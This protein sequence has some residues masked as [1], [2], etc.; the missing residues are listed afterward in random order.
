MSS[1][2]S[3]TAR[4]LVR[5]GRVVRGLVAGGRAGEY[6]GLAASELRPLVELLWL[7]ASDREPHPLFAAGFY[8]DHA[9]E[10]A[11]SGLGPLV[12]FLRFGA[13]D[14]LAPHP[15]FETS[16]YLDRYPDVAASGQN[17][18][19]HYLRCGAAELRSPHPLFDTGFYLD[20]YPEAA[21]CGLN[22]L[23][24]F[25][26]FGAAERRSPHPLFDTGYYL[27]RYPEA[28]ACGQN[29]LVHFLRFGA[30]ERRSPHPL[31][32][33]PFYLDRYPDVERSDEN[34]LLHY[35]RREA[36]ELAS[37]HP[38]FDAAY[39]VHR[40]PDV[41]ASGL[42]PLVHF[43]LFGPA[44]R[45]S[46][47]PLFDT[48]Y[49]LGRYPEVAASALNPLVHFL[50]RGAAERRSPHPLFD[51]GYY[52]DQS[53]AIGS[54]NPLLDY[55]AHGVPEGRD[56]HPL[57]HSRF[58]LDRNPDVARSGM[59]PLVHYVGCGSVERRQPHPL[60][61]PAFYA[62]RCSL[63]AG[64][65][66]LAHFLEH[67]RAARPHPLFDAASYLD[68]YPDVARS[69]ENPLAHYV[70]SGAAEGRKAA[71][72]RD[73]AA[74][75]GAPGGVSGER[76][77]S[78]KRVAVAAL[79][80]LDARVTELGAG[81]AL[82]LLRASG[83]DVS[84][85]CELGREAPADTL[86]ELS[87]LGIEVAAD[88]GVH[89]LLA[90]SSDVDVVLVDDD[91]APEVL[92]VAMALHPCSRFVLL[93]TG[94]DD[95]PPGLAAALPWIHAVISPG[96]PPAPKPHLAVEA[97]ACAHAT[98]LSAAAGP[99]GM[100]A[101]RT[102]QSEPPSATER[103]FVGLL[104]K[105]GVRQNADHSDHLETIARAAA[106]ETEADI[107]V[108]A[109]IDW[110]FRFQRPQ[111]L[112]VELARLGRRV[113]YVNPELLLEHEP[114]PYLF[115][116]SPADNVFS[117]RL[118]APGAVDIHRMLPDA[119]RAQVLRGALVA[120]ARSLAL[121]DPVVVVEAPFWHAVAGTLPRSLLVYDCM[122]LYAGFPGAHAPLVALEQELI[123]AADLVVFSSTPLAERV[124]NARR[125]AVVRNGCEFERF[126]TAAPRREG[127]RPVVGYVG[128]VDSWF[129][130]ALVERSVAA[131]PGWDF[132]LVGS[133]AGQ[134][135]GAFRPQPNLRLLGEVDYEQVPGLVAGFD[136][137]MVPFLDNE[138]TR[139][140]DPVKVYE[141]LAAGKP[142]VA[143]ALPELRRLEA[144]LVH[145]AGSD[146]EFG[147]AL[148]TAMR[149][150]H[151]AE[152]AA[153]RRRWAS[154]RSWG[155]RARELLEALQA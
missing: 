1:L 141:Y 71:A 7:G 36:G 153:R 129:D 120:V 113:A 104:R 124:T 147:A 75:G 5:L 111:Q 64:V 51:T 20:R 14:R 151:D 80:A 106:R 45:R 92:P 85:W 22:P 44:E 112:A 34:P 136:V 140:V 83:F 31:F 40:H 26:R 108:L 12:H 102:S 55:L 148:E 90:R 24:H 28:A 133:R 131:H 77:P 67:G 19:V 122:D 60:F 127:A 29:P 138:L 84:L 135:K 56:P 48:G 100:L 72:G 144:G 46:P 154:A 93:T 13:R 8:L 117:L 101:T 18:L 63:A 139:C 70:R 97:I 150:R 99:A 35:L 145:V 58:Y 103:A 3:R 57:F 15:L 33:T 86:R 17:P 123:A 142:V 37:P 62:A 137:C 54:A 42:P 11:R 49:Y 152:L 109:N 81:A 66:P 79:H 130:V 121:R 115:D 78:G 73:P 65:D 116:E 91:S 149:E 146:E 76:A 43:V 94:R 134:P 6:R 107:L 21:A 98:A 27:D 10:A 118:G 95:R 114:R 119:A 143:T 128:A 89:A 25:L 87:A 32:D 23:V 74:A 110:R 2:L 41:V 4:D 53:S 105:A 38:L 69:G 30:A 155:A 96:A 50:C 125:V 47:H 82:H 126:A 88:A 61:D 52:L 39:Y 59:N 68:R 132:V 9:P 16:F